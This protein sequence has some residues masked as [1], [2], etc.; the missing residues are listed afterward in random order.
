M[1]CKYCNTPLSDDAVFCTN[2]GKK[3]EAEVA[4][5]APAPQPTACS[6]CGAELA[7]GA[8]FCTNCGTAVVAPKAATAPLQFKLSKKGILGIIAGA[9][10]AVLIGLIILL[11]GALSSNSEED[12][13]DLYFQATCYADVDAAMDCYPEEFMKALMEAQDMKKSDLKEELKDELEEAEDEYGDFVRY[14]FE[15]VDEE[16]LDKDDLE[17][18]VEMIEEYYDIKLDITAAKEVEIEF[19]I[20]FEDDEIEDEATFVLVE[21]DGSWYIFQAGSILY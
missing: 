2:C 11:I 12:A 3:V 18:Y 13:I 1:I 9:V 20:E 8:A 15:I 14:E 5:P 17:Y 6:A 10:G 16:E 19:V 21:V 4:T 7:P